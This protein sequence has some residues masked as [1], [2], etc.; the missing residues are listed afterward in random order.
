MVPQLIVERPLMRSLIAQQYPF[1]FVDESQ[2]TTE[3]VVDALKA[4]DRELGERFCLGFFGDPMQ[5][6]YPTGIGSIS[7]GHGWVSI[8]KPENFRCPATV[9]S[10]ANAIRR[11]GDGLIQTRGRMT[12]SDGALVS[13]PGS[14]HLFIL[15]IDE[16]RDQLITQVR[17]WVAEKNDDQVWHTD[18]H[19][20]AVRLLVIVHRMAAKRLGFGDLYAALND[21]APEKFKNGFLD[22]TAWPVRPF[23]NFVVPLV[24]ANKNGKDFE[25]MQLL[26]NQ[27]PLLIQKN[28]REVNIVQRLDELRHFRV[29]AHGLS[30]VIRL[31]LGVRRAIQGEQGLAQVWEGLPEIGQRIQ[32][33]QRDSAEHRGIQVP[34]LG[35]LRRVHVAR[36]VEVVVVGLALQLGLGDQTA[37]AGHGGAGDHNIGDLFDVAGAELVVLAHFAEA[38]GGVH[39]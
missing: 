20:E 29:L 32:F 24:S 23:N 5:R 36:N 28:L 21:H 19:N 25:V 26:R 14:V 2:D 30:Q 33:A 11:D 16:R 13:I 9:L 17:S 6:I 7:A 39:E 3:N 8:T 35:G 4:V 10:V 34:A 22:G 31:R 18:E 15:P 37:E 27:S 38:L 12:G 1:L